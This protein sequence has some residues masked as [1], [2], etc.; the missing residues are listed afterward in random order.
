MKPEQCE[1]CRLLRPPVHMV[2]GRGGC[3]KTP[4]CGWKDK[5]VTQV[6]DCMGKW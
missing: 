6:H 5:P 3:Y 4:I 2:S 1:G